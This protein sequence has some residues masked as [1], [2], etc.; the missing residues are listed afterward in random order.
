MR[1]FPQTLSV[2]F[3]RRI[4]VLWV[5]VLFSSF[6]QSQSVVSVADTTGWAPWKLPNGSAITDVPN[7]QQTGQKTDDF[8]GNS[9]TYAFQQKAGTIGGTDYIL[10]RARMGDFQGVNQVGGNGMNIGVGFNLDSSANGSIDLIMMMSK[11]NSTSATL[12]FG[13][14][15]SGANDGPSTTTWTFPSQTA[16]TLTIYNPASPNPGTGTFYVQSATAVDSVKL[17]T[18]NSSTEDAWV[19]FGVSFA[20]LQTAARTFSKDSASFSSYT[21]TYSTPI[22]MIGF[23]STQ[24]SSLNQDLAGVTGGVGSSASSSSFATLGAST[25]PTTVDPAP[26][27]EPS[28]FLMVPALLIPAFM[29]FRRRQS[30]V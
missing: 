11:T 6:G 4:L 25:T 7:D 2:S 26:V 17:N 20:T 14:P 15:G 12:S 9:T 22:T 28:T 24:N 10:L 5:T 27:P 30:F 23:T 1:V 19:T 16:V 21:V 13:T 29:L 3:L 8:V 18:G